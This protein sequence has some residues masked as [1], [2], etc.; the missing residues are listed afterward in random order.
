MGKLFWEDLTREQ[1]AAAR[2][3]GAVVA[4]PVGAIEQHGGHM[5]VGTDSLLSRAVTG[6][7]AEL[8]SATVLVAPPLPYGFSPHHLAHAGTISLRLS[9]Y[10]SVLRDMAT[11]L[12]ETGFR[13]IVF[14]NG[15]G[16]NSAPLR[17]CVAELVTDGVPATGV[18]Y[19]VPA[20]AD[21]TL[22]LAG[23]TRRFGHACEF[24][25]SLVLAATHDRPELRDRVLARSRDLAPRT[26]QPWILP[27][28]EGDP[29]TDAGAAWPPL[30]QKDDPGY[31]GDPAAATAENGAR[32]L[33]VVA[34]GLARYFDGF[35]R[36]RLR[37]GRGCNGQEVSEPVLAGAG[38]PHGGQP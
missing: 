19:W 33:E 21:W 16:G 7:A 25:T 31:F 14:V 26:V 22:L 15:H 32:I 23:R 38:Q 5:P 12:A 1:I 34:G 4:L 36:T 37:V 17:S 28:S 2:D 35:A 11:S 10:L 27:G 13:R 9:T 3:A 24:E 29:V 20:Q 8:A 30:F 6:R 18:D